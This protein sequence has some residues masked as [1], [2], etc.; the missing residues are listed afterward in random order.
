MKQRDIKKRKFKKN[1]NHQQKKKN[2]K[3]KTNNAL[4]NKNSRSQLS[5][6]ISH[7]GVSTDCLFS[8]STRQMGHRLF[9]GSHWSTHSIWNRCMHGKR[10]TASPSPNSHRQ[11]V[12][13]WNGY[14][15]ELSA[16]VVGGGDG[17]D[18]GGLDHVA[19]EVLW[20]F[21][22]WI[23]RIYYRGTSFISKS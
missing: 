15:T 19:K 21:S 18:G 7:P 4:S 20:T 14:D 22:Y 9:V 8:M 6:K 10:L 11:I 13:F 23:I 17:G 12:H 2:F 5:G 1:K 16:A 3:T